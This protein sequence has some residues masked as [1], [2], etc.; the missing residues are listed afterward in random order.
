MFFFISIHE[1][2]IL[3]FNRKLHSELFI[4]CIELVTQYSRL[5]SLL[6]YDN[7]I[8]E[9]CLCLKIVLHN[10]ILFLNYVF[11]CFGVDNTNVSILEHSVF[12][13]I[14]RLSE[15]PEMNRH[16]FTRAFI[17]VFQFPLLKLKVIFFIFSAS[18]LQ[19]S[20]MLFQ[21]RPFIIDFKPT[22]SLSYA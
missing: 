2:F 4:P 11:N 6:L 7:L 17:I 16:R 13:V 10:S 22:Y 3:I 15:C 19:L 9:H 21:R 14:G 1:Q 8:T 5:G 18:F 12:C 20:T